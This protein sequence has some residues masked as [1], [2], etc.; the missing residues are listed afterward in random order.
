MNASRQTV[1]VAIDFSPDSSAALAWAARYADLSG[2]SLVLLHV[3]HDPAGSPGF[4]R[5][6]PK[7]NMQPMQEI[8][9]QMME[10][11]LRAFREEHPGHGSVDTAESQFVPGLPPTRIVEVAKLLE[12]EIIVVGS[13]GITGLPHML[14]GSVAERVVELAECPVIVVKSEEHQIHDK[15]TIKRLAKQQKKERKKLKRLLGVTPESESDRETD[16]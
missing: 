14:L 15:K 2:A 8:A 9:A 7:D 4:Y 13:R 11:F 12:A 6:S 3:V 10:D 1:L 5:R 16:D